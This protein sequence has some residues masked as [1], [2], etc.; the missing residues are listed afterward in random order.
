MVNQLL[1]V[2]LP[3]FANVQLLDTDWGFVH[4]DSSISCHH[5]F[6]FLQT[7]P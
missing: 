7:P 3:K 6:D 1:K 5:V 2:S 4:S